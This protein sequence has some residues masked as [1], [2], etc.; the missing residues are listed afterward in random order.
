MNRFAIRT[1]YWSALLCAATF[2]LFTIAFA[3]I[4]LAGPLYVWDDLAGYVADTATRSQT[5]KVV[6]QA[7][8]LLFAPLFVLL[9]ASIHDV[10]GGE[11]RFLARA[12]LA[13]SIPFATLA[14]VHYFVQLSTV[15]L[16]VAAGAIEGLA[17]WIQANPSAAI[18]AVNMTG[19]TL[20]LGFASL[21]LAGVFSGQGVERV[22]RA[23]FV[24]N[25]AVC[26][27]AGI[28]FVANWTAVVFVTINLGMGAALLVAFVGLL[29][30]F[31]RLG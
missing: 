29:I 18:L 15:R 22:I 30:W 19:F 21:F 10:T 4:A 6:A 12:G 7:A 25:G 20:F 27:I 23:A 8:M 28:A 24:A 9:A 3:G 13:L 17:H 11:R 2:M 1:G 31:R 14:A 5:L 26:L 16:N